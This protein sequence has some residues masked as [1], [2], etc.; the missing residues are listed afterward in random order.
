MNKKFVYQVG[1]NK[2]VK[3][4]KVFRV[5]LIALKICLRGGSHLLN[6]FFE[7]KSLSHFEYFLI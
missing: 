3:P 4:Y 2:K 6:Y 5:F 7:Y 1:N